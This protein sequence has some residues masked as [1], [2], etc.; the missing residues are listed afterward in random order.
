MQELGDLLKTVSVKAMDTER[1]SEREREGEKI[2]LEQ[3]C[4]K[5][6]RKRSDE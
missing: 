3:R 6:I 5:W 4:G 2:L 1:V